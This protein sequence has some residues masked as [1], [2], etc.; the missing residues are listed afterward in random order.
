[1]I[2]RTNLTLL[3]VMIFF[4]LSC[5]SSEIK[6]DFIPVDPVTVDP[7]PVDTISVD[8]TPVDTISVDPTPVDPVPEKTTY[9]KDVKTLINNSCATAACHGAD[10]P[11][12][13]LALTNY[14][15]V[16]NSAINGNLIGRINS[17]SNPMPPSGKNN[18]IIAIIDK[19]KNDGYLEN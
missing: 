6:D 17:S 19:W 14:E 13:G 10:N 12:Y 7:A 9:D 18:T 4:L 11:P 2:H 8:P 15:Q 3:F 16:K 1:M 5:S